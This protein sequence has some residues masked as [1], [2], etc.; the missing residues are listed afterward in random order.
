[1]TLQSLM[2]QTATVLR[3]PD[4]VSER[5][6]DPSGGTPI[7]AEYPCRLE[8]TTSQEI[9]LGRATQISDWILF[10]PWNADLK[11]D[12]VVR[13]GGLTYEVVG[14]PIQARTVGRVDHVE[15]RLRFVKA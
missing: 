13:V 11:A 8:Q 2:D 1:V 3:S 12:D 9:T 7:E 14:P 5:Y 4:T 10:L 15:A 6:N